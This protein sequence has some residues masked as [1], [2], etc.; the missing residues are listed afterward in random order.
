MGHRQAI[1]LGVA[2]FGGICHAGAAGIGQTQGAGNLVKGFAGGIVHGVAQNVVVGIVLHLHDMAVAAGCHQTEEGRLELRMGQVKGRNVAP[3]VMH[4]NQRLVGR[5]GQPLGKVH[6]HQHRAD[7]A[8]GKGDSHRVHIVHGLASIQQSLFD[9]GA[10]ELAVA[11]AGDLR[12]NAAI[13]SLLLDAGGDD[14]AQQA[15]AILHK[16]CGGLVAGGFDS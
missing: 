15:A 7:Q 9:R 1:G 12:D 10:D 5:I 4:R 11:A 14:V 8:R 6:T 2:C 3:Q 13:K 16:G